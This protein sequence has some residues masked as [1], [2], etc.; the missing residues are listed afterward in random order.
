MA[1]CKFRRQKVVAGGKLEKAAN[2]RATRK[3]KDAVSLLKARQRK[4]E[5]CRP[6]TSKGLDERGSRPRR[7]FSLRPSSERLKTRRGQKRRNKGNTT[8]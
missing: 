2:N 5:A 1:E 4:A 8:T 6:S 3:K 7:L